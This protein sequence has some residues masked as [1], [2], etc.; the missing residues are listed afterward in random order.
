MATADDPTRAADE[1]LED[2]EAELAAAERA[3]LRIGIRGRNLALLP[4]AAWFGLASTYPG[5]LLALLA[6]AGFLAL[7]LLT[8]AVLAVAVRRAREVVRARA[9]SERQRARVQQVF[10]RYVPG[11]V[12]E[13]LLSDGG[14]LAA[15]TRTASILFVDIE[16]FTQFAEGRDPERV[17]AVLNAYFD[18]VARIIGEQGGVVISFIGDA[19]MAAFN[20][21]LPMEAHAAGALRA[22]Q[23]LLALAER[24]RFEGEALKVRVGVATGPVAAGSVGGG[25][26]QT[27]TVYGDTVNLAQRLEAKNKELG[28]RLLVCG[29]TRAACGAASLAEVGELPIRGRS[30]AVRVFAPAG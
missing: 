10:G 25:G 15:Q 14:S 5:N 6:M 21:P 19:V 12:A 24:E 29:E 30:E 22:G 23:A 2:V 13:A 1:G 4:I 11:E 17:I 20:A 9:R 27:Y 28:T 18:R 26:R 7:G 3:G 8:A 16:G